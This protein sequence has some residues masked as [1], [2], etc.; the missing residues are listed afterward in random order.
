MKTSNHFAYSTKVWLTSAFIAPLLMALFAV[1]TDPKSELVFIIP[2]MIGFGLLFSIPNW[3]L[4]IISVWQINKFDFPNEEKKTIIS[5]IAFFLTLGLFVFIFQGESDFMGFS[6]PYIIVLIFGIWKYELI[7]PIKK[8]E[9]SPI[10][11][12]I[13]VLEDILDDENY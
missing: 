6:I 10:S 5:F 13:K 4:L 3:I 9:R 11:K 12:R 2:F 7:P 1:I 8:V